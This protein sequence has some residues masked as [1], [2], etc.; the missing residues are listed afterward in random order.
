MSKC[1]LRWR[2]QILRQVHQRLNFNLG[3]LM[4]KQHLRGAPWEDGPPSARPGRL[5]QALVMS[6]VTIG[7]EEVPGK[8]LCDEAEC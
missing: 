8:G 4:R 3:M 7:S 2:Q 1:C 6:I 5:S